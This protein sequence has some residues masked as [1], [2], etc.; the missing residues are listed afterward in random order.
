MFKVYKGSFEETINVIFN[1]LDFEDRG[2]IIKDEV[3]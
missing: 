1:I 2:F 3:K